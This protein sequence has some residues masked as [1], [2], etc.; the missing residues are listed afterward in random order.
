MPRI[1]LFVTEPPLYL[2]NTKLIQSATNE[3]LRARKDKLR[4]LRE[5]HYDKKYIPQRRPPEFR[6]IQLELNQIETERKRRKA[7][8]AAFAQSQPK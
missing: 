2:N 1:K 8:R 4:K 7:M 5:L 3:E 6:D